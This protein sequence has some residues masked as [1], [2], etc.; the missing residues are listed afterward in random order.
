MFRAASGRQM[1]TLV[2]AVL[3][4]IAIGSPGFAQST[5]MVKG[6]VIDGEN[7]PVSDAKITIDYLE[8]I[9]RR[10][11]VKSNRR[12]EFTQIGLPPGQYKVTAEKD[13][14]GAQSFDVRVR[15]GDATEV[16]FVLAPGAVG[17]TK[18]DLAKGAELKELFDAGVEASRTGQYDEAIA[19]FQA[20]AEIVPGCYDCLYNIGFAHAQKK[21][22]DNAEASF[23]AAIEMKPDYVEAFNGLATVYNAQKKFDLA[24]QASQ[25]AAEHAA[26][27]AAAG[28]SGAGSVDALYNQGVIAWNAGDVPAAKKHFEEV[29]KINP[30]HAEAH[31]QLGMALLNEGKLPEAAAE[32]ET[33]LRLAPDGQFAPQAKGIVSTIKK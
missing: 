17:P 20:A 32:F 23:K 28:G 19:K 15:L 8:G 25:Q 14:L 3:A 31:Y 9:N 7:Q 10:F 6:K 33:Y 2:V 22:Y 21:D 18:D 1:L 24:Q 11:E 5:G 13:K 26:A 27:S 30:D 29:L 16:N 4:V 12:G